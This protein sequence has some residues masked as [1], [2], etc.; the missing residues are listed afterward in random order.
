MSKLSDEDIAAV[1]LK[2]IQDN[3]MASAEMVQDRSSRC[4]ID[5]GIRDKKLGQILAQAEAAFRRPLDRE[6]LRWVF[7]TT[8]GEMIDLAKAKLEASA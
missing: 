3:T 2:A 5:L 8:V 4:M 7:A 6:D 1:M